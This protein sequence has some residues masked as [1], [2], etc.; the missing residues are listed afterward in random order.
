MWPTTIS[1]TATC[2]PNSCLGE[3]RLSL[4]SVTTLSKE[5]ADADRIRIKYEK[6]ITFWPQICLTG[7][8]KSE[9]VR[10]LSILR[11][12]F[13]AFCLQ[14]NLQ[15]SARHS[16]W[17]HDPPLVLCEQKAAVTGHSEASTWQIA[18]AGPYQTNRVRKCPH[19]CVCTSWCL[20]SYAL[21]KFW[22]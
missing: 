19:L 8:R 18:I 11:C 15:V 14:W 10:N 1:M 16:V 7:M 21:W 5:L 17:E 22:E 3:W 20:V 9:H 6:S 4:V 12:L 2:R 13:Y